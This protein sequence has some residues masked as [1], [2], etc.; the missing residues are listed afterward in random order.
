[1]EAHPE[2]SFD[3]WCVVEVRGALDEAS[4]GRAAAAV[5]TTHEI[6]Q[7]RF[8]RVPGMAIPVQEIHP[9]AVRLVRYEAAGP[10]ALEAWLEERWRKAGGLPAE[11]TAPLTLTWIEAATE[12]SVLA[13]ELSGPCGDGLTVV[14]LVRGLALAYGALAS[15]A[16]EPKAEAVQY[17]DVAEVFNDLAESEEAEAARSLWQPPAGLGETGSLPFPSAV[18][19]AAGPGFVRRALELPAAR[20]AQLTDRAEELGADPADLVEAAWL[21][22]LTRHSE[23][24]PVPWLHL[25]SGR[26]YEGLDTAAGPFARLLP[27]FCGGAPRLSFAEW[28]IRLRDARMSAQERQDLFDPGAI[29]AAGAPNGARVAF[30]ALE[31]PPL[32]AAGEPSWRFLR[33]HWRIGLPALT[34]RYF[35]G[36]GTGDLELIFDSN[37]M[38]AAGAVHLLNQ[39][40]TLLGHA[41]D[42]PFRAVA[43]LALEEGAAPGQTGPA[44]P[45]RDLRQE[46]AR[47]AAETPELVAVEAPEGTWTY[48]DLDERA[49][50]LAR[51]LA[52]L[53]VRRESVVGV[54]MGRQRDLVVALLAVLE[55]GGAYL[56]LDPEHPPERLNHLLKDAGAGWILVGE[57][58]PIPPVQ[59]PV[60]VLTMAQLNV[61]ETTEPRSFPPADPRQLAYVLYTSGTTGRPKGVMVEHGSLWNYLAW[62]RDHLLPTVDWLPMTSRP[63]F[64]ASLKQIFG[65]LL[66]GRSLW[67]L[68]QAAL[69][70]PASLVRA[71]AKRRRVALNVVPSV[72]RA[73]LDVLESAGAANLEASL[74]ALWVGG[75][76]MTQ[77]DLA[78]TFQRFPRLEVRNLYGP[79]EA[80]ANLCAGALRPQSPPRL[81]KPLDGCRAEI[82]DPDLKRQATG[83]AG[84]LAAA[85]IAVARGYLGMPGRTAASFLPDPYARA[86]GSRLYLTGDR[87]R[88]D[89][90]GE[91]EFLGR[92]DRQVK[93]RGIRIELGEVENSLLRLSEVTE[94]AVDLR[95]L[96]A[97]VGLVAWVVPTGQSSLETLREAAARELPAALVPARF[98]S[99]LALPRTSGGKVDFRA[100]PEP[101][102]DAAEHRSPRTPVEEVV[103][104]FWCELLGLDSAGMARIG[105]DDNFLAL[106]GHSLLAVQ[107]LSRIHSAFAVDLPLRDILDAAD[108]EVLAARIE[109]ARNASPP[110]PMATLEPGAEDYRP[111]SFS[112]ERLWF[113]AQ[114]EPTSPAYNIP[115]SLRLEGEVDPGRLQRAL[116][117]VA[118]RHE[119]L[120]TRYPTK[121]GRPVRE[122]LAQ[123]PEL[124]GVV[125]LSSLAPA[126]RQRATERWIANEAVAPF[127][128]GRDLPVRLRLLRTGPGEWILLAT[129][130]HI[131]SDGWSSRLLLQDLAR[132]YQSEALEP[133]PF[134]YADYAA[135]QRDWFSGETL[136]RRRSFWRNRLSGCRPTTVPTDRPRPPVLSSRGAVVRRELAAELV[137]GLKTLSRQRGVTLFMTTLAAFK[138]V[139]RYLSGS[140][141]IVVGTDAVNRH[142]PG[143]PEVMGL[144][145]N[146]LVLRTQLAAGIDFS[147]ALRRV[148]ETTLTAYDHQDLPFN[149]LVEAVQPERNLSRNPLF[150]VMFAY[151]NLPP[152]PAR[153][154]NLELTSLQPETDTAVFD[155]SVYLKDRPTGLQGVLRYSTDLFETA[156]IERLWELFERVLVAVVEDAEISLDSLDR[157][158]GDFDQQRSQGE[159]AAAQQAAGRKLRSRSDRRSRSKSI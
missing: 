6:L 111:M 57:G 140:Q 7:T 108:L 97:G 159:A 119:V 153:L 38:L 59:A 127:D 74:T 42:S 89:A 87:A 149:L 105:L 83:V 131:V 55:A 43:G 31:L 11:G 73:V 152:L 144:F 134:Q 65:P 56:P 76:A 54:A 118:A 132:A 114:L 125:D 9:S 71:L 27:L 146:Q 151:L 1:M 93:L 15:G 94:C 82:L 98:V 21:V 120:R 155:L 92:R 103:A 5:Q 84:E 156:T 29:P 122:I 39:L 48:R 107:L 91:L 136:E 44:A 79:T 30:E 37:R 53:G 113:L 145:V 128:L 46:I 78:R 147:E 24:H 96:P 32:Q 70:D 110:P 124:Q 35:H 40:V 63:T 58:L 41:L 2:I 148:R 138:V 16:H 19:P 137:S 60:E 112:Q 101:E 25:F 49:S 77:E 130:H 10:G 62:I 3:S 158:L 61:G 50:R 64:D 116:G 95:D 90:S 154:G 72:W 14:N 143:S 17:A 33:I 123:G 139:L 66:R 157:I 81:G 85:G 12:R 13:L 117:L 100:L 8:R 142:R 141:D 126:Q 80:T 51:R 20:I 36:P 45:F 150:Q 133:A 104:G 52:L 129:L 22:L 67:C 106:G 28:V 4:L 88:R 69:D 75:E 115:A 23:G 86:E 47:R 68:P 99:V 109:K 135:W 102:A 34:L 18:G 121:E 26:E